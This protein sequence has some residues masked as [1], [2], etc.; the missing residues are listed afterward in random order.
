MKNLVKGDD[1]ENI[2]DGTNL[3]L[4][5]LLKPC[6]KNPIIFNESNSKSREVRN[7]ETI[8]KGTWNSIFSKTKLNLKEGLHHQECQKICRIC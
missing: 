5:Y 3:H 7:I 2:K 6:Y 1:A 4:G 8:L